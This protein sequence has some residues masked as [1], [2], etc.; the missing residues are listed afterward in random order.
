MARANCTL[1]TFANFVFGELRGQLLVLLVSYAM[2]L[3]ALTN[4][5]VHHHGMALD[6]VL[7]HREFALW[8][9]GCGECIDQFGCPYETLASTTHFSG[10]LI[11][12]QI[13]TLIA[14][15][16]PLAAM[17]TL[18]VKRVRWGASTFRL[19][20]GKYLSF[21]VRART[22]VDYRCMLFS[23]MALCIQCVGACFVVLVSCGGDPWVFLC[24]TLA[25]FACYRGMQSHA[26]TLQ[27]DTST[28]VFRTTFF[29]RKKRTFCMN[30]GEFLRDVER[31]I[32]SQKETDVTTSNHNT[33][34]R[35]IS[36]SRT[37]SEL[38]VMCL[39]RSLE[40]W[41]PVHVERP[42]G[43]TMV[44]LQQCACIR[45]PPI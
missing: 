45:A 3:E 21:C 44:T 14:A 7:S 22:T 4:Y 1:L 2:L 41:L 17:I 33:P 34:N 42:L 26:K 43:S 5:Y 30:A 38:M 23:S 12:T 19:D 15:M 28:E 11:S 35:D 37:G 6:C 31:T 10:A 18:I 8:D 40:P 20:H 32:L 13:T 39:E 24:E 29:T 36:E 16:Y 9:W 27:M 25:L